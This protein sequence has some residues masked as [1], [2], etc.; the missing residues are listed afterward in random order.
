MPL[1]ASASVAASADEVV[2]VALIVLVADADQTDLD[3]V[4]LFAVIGC[5]VVVLGAAGHQAQSHD[6][7]KDLFHSIFLL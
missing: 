7:R 1:A 4:G 5:V 3:G 2:G 6:Q